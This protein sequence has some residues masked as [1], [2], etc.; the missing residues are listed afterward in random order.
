VLHAIAEGLSPGAAARV[1]NL[2]Q[3]RVHSWITRAGQHSQALHERLRH[4][5]HL[6]RVQLDE[7]RLKLYGAAEA[8]WLWVGYDARTKLIPAFTLGRRTQ[9]LAHQLIHT[10][11]SLS[12]SGST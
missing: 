2:S 11:K 5:L 1:F 4:T 9:A 12:S 3:T 8:G 6:T 10:S 7:L